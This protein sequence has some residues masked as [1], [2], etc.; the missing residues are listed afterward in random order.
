[1]NKSPISLF[2]SLIF[3]QAYLRLYP[4]TSKD[5]I[6]NK[7]NTYDY[8]QND[9]FSK[10][11]NSLYE[12]LISDLAADSIQKDTYDRGLESCYKSRKVKY[13][14]KETKEKIVERVQVEKKGAFNKQYRETYSRKLESV[15]TNTETIEKLA[16]RLTEGTISEDDLPLLDKV[17]KKNRLR[18]ITYIMATLI[19]LI[20]IVVILVFFK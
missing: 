1:M 18:F 10:D 16:D 3:N 11:I 5:G 19:V 2:K 20:A 12:Y 6:V 14:D 7:I 4:L 9:D 13:K 15:N 17:L 8:T